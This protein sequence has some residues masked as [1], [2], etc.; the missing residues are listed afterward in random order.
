M[1]VSRRVVAG[2]ASA[3]GDNQCETSLPGRDDPPEPLPPITRELRLAGTVDARNM[4]A[5]RVMTGTHPQWMDS[6]VGSTGATGKH[7]L[8]GVLQTW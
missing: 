7:L 8:P 2:K 3:D 6:W 1:S 5:T 4:E